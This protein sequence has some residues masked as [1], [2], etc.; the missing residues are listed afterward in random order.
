[1]TEVREDVASGATV[2]VVVATDADQGTNGNVLYEI[3][4]GDFDSKNKKSLFIVTDHTNVIPGISG[5]KMYWYT[6]Y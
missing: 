5:V 1:M 3:T 2:L 4:N 6:T